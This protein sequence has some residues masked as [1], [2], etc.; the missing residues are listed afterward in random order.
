MHNSGLQ[1]A[2]TSDVHNSAPP[3]LHVGLSKFR[4]F[5]RFPREMCSPLVSNSKPFPP[6][7]LPLCLGTRVCVRERKRA[8]AHPHP[9]SAAA[10]AAC[11][12][13]QLPPP[14]SLF[15]ASTKVCARSPSLWMRFC[16]LY[17]SGRQI[18]IDRLE[19][20]TICFAFRHA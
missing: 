10:A 1:Y 8:S 11:S 5:P 9:W 16:S 20:F 13:M 18:G 14:Q 15:C 19:L 4:Y 6:N 12:S 7:H 2:P 3:V 17:L